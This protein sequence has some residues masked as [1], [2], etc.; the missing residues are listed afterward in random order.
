MKKNNIFIEN[1]IFIAVLSQ[2][3][4]GTCVIPQ[5]MRRNYMW[6]ICECGHSDT[7]VPVAKTLWNTV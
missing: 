4:K 6:M 7:A 2:H 5:V 3:N 1:N